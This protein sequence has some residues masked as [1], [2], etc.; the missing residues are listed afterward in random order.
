MACIAMNVS[1]QVSPVTVLR[2]SEAAFHILQG[3]GDRILI[4]ILYLFR[5]TNR[6]GKDCQQL[7]SDRDAKVTSVFIRGVGIS[8]VFIRTK[9]GT[10]V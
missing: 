3:V 10:Y 9:Q 6:R 7:A 2:W 8:G 5:P 4:R 1:T